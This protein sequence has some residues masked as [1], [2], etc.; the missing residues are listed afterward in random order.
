[1]LVNQELANAAYGGGAHSIGLNQIFDLILPDAPGHFNTANLEW[2]RKMRQHASVFREEWDAFEAFIGGEQGLKDFT[3]WEQKPYWKTVYLTQIGNVNELMAAH[4]PR[5]LSV[6]FSTPILSAAFSVLP[7]GEALQPHNGEYKGI[8]R[9]HLTL[10]AP[11]KTVGWEDTW[12]LMQA[13]FPA[14]DM[15]PLQ[16]L[17]HLRSD[18]GAGLVNPMPADEPIPAAHLGVLIPK[19]G[20]EPATSDL[21]DMAGIVTLGYSIR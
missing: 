16:Q 10:W 7:P 1:M 9:Y 2:A 20:V 5:T 21:N 6:L 19:E 13:R 17:P 18:E 11:N 8:L 3:Y 4:F 15:Y 12:H 14:M